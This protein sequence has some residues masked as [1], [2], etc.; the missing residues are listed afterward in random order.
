MAKNNGK[1]FTMV[2]LEKK[3]VLEVL[4]ELMEKLGSM[5]AATKEEYRATGEL[6]QLTRWDDATEKR[7]PV[8]VDSD[9]KDTFEVTDNPRMTE[10]YDYLPKL[11]FTD[12]DNA[13]LAAI[14]KIRETLA[15]LA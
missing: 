8:Y 9:D 5:E 10:K 12:R 3:A 7:R 14:D 15:S 6:Y 11:E 1:D 2:V 4:E 13:K